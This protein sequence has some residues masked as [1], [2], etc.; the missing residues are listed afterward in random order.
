[1]ARLLQGHNPC[2]N[3]VL[4]STMHG[5]E[6]EH[7]HKLDNYLGNVC[8]CRLLVAVANEIGC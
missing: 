1:V 5:T 3:F 6:I 8:Y 4:G 2:D 7:L